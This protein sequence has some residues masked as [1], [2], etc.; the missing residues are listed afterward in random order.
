MTSFM[1]Y[2]LDESGG[3]ISSSAGSSLSEGSVVAR[4]GSSAL[5]LVRHV[6]GSGW[7]VGY[8]CVVNPQTRSPTCTGAHRSTHRQTDTHTKK[9]PTTTHSKTGAR[10]PEREEVHE[11]THALQSLKVVF[12]RRMRN[13]C[14]ESGETTMMPKGRSTLVVR[15]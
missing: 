4:I 14:N 7:V 12:K 9:K 8:G 3:T 11:G 10:T 2:A 5:L 1:L 6:C 13:T 15:G